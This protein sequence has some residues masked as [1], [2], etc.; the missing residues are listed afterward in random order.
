MTVKC[1]LDD[2]VMKFNQKAERDEAL[3]EELEGITRKVQIDLG[4]EQY[5]FILENKRI[6]SFTEGRIENPDISLISDPRT[7]EDLVSGKMK[8]MKAWALKKLKIKGSLDD[9]LRLRKF[10]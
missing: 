7:I 3:Q 4:S 9:V 2:L 6:G 10:F 1:L 5:K 8:P